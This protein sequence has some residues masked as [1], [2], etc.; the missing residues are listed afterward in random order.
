MRRK[1]WNR[2][3]TTI[4]FYPDRRLNRTVLKILE[5]IR[6]SNGEGARYFNI[7]GFELRCRF[8]GSTTQFEWH[9]FNYGSKQWSE[10][11][12]QFNYDYTFDQMFWDIRLLFKECF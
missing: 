1:F 11:R 4:T 12:D 7:D 10:L 9:E 5:A 3:K 2:I 8:D 6:A